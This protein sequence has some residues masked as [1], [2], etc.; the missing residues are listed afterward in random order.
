MKTFAIFFLISILLS[1]HTSFATEVTCFKEDSSITLEGTLHRSTFPGSP[2]YESIRKGDKPET[3]WILKLPQ[4]ICISTDKTIQSLQLIVNPV[5]YKNRKLL[6]IKVKVAG[7]L[8]PQITG[9][10]HTLFLIDV[11]TIQ[12]LEN[13][14]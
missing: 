5:L 10:H 3:Y 13:E 1:I 6:R 9:H 4:P 14:K 8:T 7:T 12:S 11:K 2:N